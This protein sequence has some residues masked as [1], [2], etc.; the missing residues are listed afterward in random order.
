MDTHAYKARLE[1]EKAKLEMEL[2]TVARKNPSNPRDWE[3]IPQEVGQ[4]PDT[5]DAADL[6][7][8]YGENAAI[9]AELEPRYEGVLAALARI[10]AGT[11]GTCLVSGEPIE[12]ARLNADP[13][14]TTCMTHMAGA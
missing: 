8:G 1:E 11:Y 13:A 6:Q 5:N 7:E 12:E 4:E 2:A 9:L 14:A 10:D 3:A